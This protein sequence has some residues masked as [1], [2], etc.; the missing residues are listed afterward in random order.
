MKKNFKKFL[1]CAM[2]LVMVVTSVTV[3]STVAKGDMTT[4]QMVASGIYNLALGKSIT[5][6]PSRQEGNE[7]ALLDGDLTGNHAATTFNTA[8]TYY[9]IDLGAYYDASTIDQ[10]AVQYK[11]YNTNDI[12][13]KGYKIQYSADGINFTE[14][15]AISATEFT[16]QVTAE[17][18]LE[19]QDLTEITGAV[20]YIRLFYPDSYRYG[21][22]AREIAVLDVDMNAATVT[23]EKCDEAAG[24]NVEVTD[25][26]TIT[27]SIVAGENQENYVYM[28]YLNGTTKIGH[29]VQADTDYTVS[30]IVSGLH[31]LKVVAIDNG[32]MSDGITSSQVAVTDISSLISSAKN[33]SN[34]N[35]NSLASVVEVSALYDEHSMT[36]AQVALDGKI[37]TGEGTD[38]AL[39][40]ASGSPQYVVIDLGDYYTPDEMD[41]VLIGY[42][43]NRTYAAT[44]KVEFSLDNITYDTVGEST[45]FECVVDGS[46]AAL[47]SVKIDTAD[48]AQAA[49]RYIKITLS[50]G[51]SGYGYVVNEIA[52]IANTDEPTIM[53]SDIP[54]AADIIIDTENLET[55]KYTVVASEGQEDAIYVIKLGEQIVNSSAV[56]GTE[57]IL[58]NIEAGTYTLRACTLQDGWQSKG[59]T[60]TATV[61]GYF[62]YVKDTLNL[63]LKAEHPNVTVTCDN[64]NYGDNYL[65]GSQDISAGVDA[66][67]DG[68]YE[69]HSHHSGY[70]QTRPDSSEANI[71][72]DL[73]RDYL[74]TDIH[75][76]I[77]MYESANNCATEYEI[78][79]SSDGEN[80]EQVF[81]IK[82][83][84][85]SQLMSAF[86]DVS[87]YTQET[88]RYVKY[89]IINGNYSKHYKDD[90]SI[91]W[92]STGYHLCELVVM[93]K[94]NL[95][96]EKVSGVTVETPTY[97]KVVV[98]W[99]D[100]D[101]P[102]ATYRVY[103]N[104]LVIV[105]DIASGVQTATF[106]IS[107]G[108]Y[109]VAVA[110]VKDEFASLYKSVSVTVENE[111]TTPAP[112]TP[113]PTT[114]PTTPTPTQK[115]TQ[116]PTVTPT[117]APTVAPT[118]APTTEAKK[119]GRVTIK[120]AKAGKKKVSLKLKKVK[121]ANGYRI[122][123]AT[124]KKLKN[125]KTKMTKSVN[126][127]IKKLKKG[128]KYYF[129]AQAY[130]LVNGKKLY[131]N[132][133]KV[134]ASKKVK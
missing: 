29:A 48:Y 19:V 35:Y 77:A 118:Q 100:I 54:E 41:K 14:V 63:A 126:V 49:V 131:G 132:W 27:Y 67:N 108:T 125:A 115:P 45:G 81:Y 121:G 22:Q 38:K 98:N 95:L 110:V 120:K 87:S 107:G 103:L 10:L 128:K 26:N 31:T 116:K 83:A 82:D 91:N 102:N 106:T 50:A 86:V 25:Y 99:V 68:I 74:P 70:L 96:P 134:K 18:L 72:Y 3:T 52:V 123:Y 55:I 34:K 56:A 5:A 62:S 113:K 89:H 57:Y 111:T 97:N 53:G 21:I 42:S 130:K 101:D 59:I 114:Q 44:T 9:E 92:G 104:G 6:N 30:G 66:L 60:K 64:D 122:K 8:G 28:V 105:K 17:N 40:T 78:L 112:T 58:E 47:N 24:I 39:R 23:V 79:F 85:F 11:E 4:A 61:K 124:N 88:V 73:A 1:S 36:T 69:N 12:P 75:S 94:E 46:T 43:N 2:S 51:A 127:V 37:E 15:K 84:K 16:S 109:E 133:S 65:T 32:K 90:G 119:L 13:V 7:A 33:L 93:G 76:V 117:Q 71:V 80:Y 20:R 129:K